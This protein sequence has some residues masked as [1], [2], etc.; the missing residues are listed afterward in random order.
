MALSDTATF[1]KRVFGVQG[2]MVQMGDH[3]V[4]GSKV[5]GR[6]LGLGLGFGSV[7]DFED[8]EAHRV[9]G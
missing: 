5:Y 4:R 1:A 7:A 6:T 2:F 9:W 3:G 8:S